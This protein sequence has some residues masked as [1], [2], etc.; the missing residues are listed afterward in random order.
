MKLAK[1]A[2][3]LAAIAALTALVGVSAASAAQY[4]SSASPVSLSGNQNN[5]IVFSIHGQN[6]SCTS[7]ILT[8]NGLATPANEVSGVVVSFS[9][10]TA[11][12]FAAAINMG[13][14]T[15]NFD[16]PNAGLT[17]TT[18]VVCTSN[19]NVTGNATNNGDARILTNVFGSVCEVHLESQNNK[20]TITF[21]NNNPVAGDFLVM[22]ALNSLTAEVTQDNGLCPLSGTGVTNTATLNGS[23]GVTGDG[24]TTVSIG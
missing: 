8:R 7:V 15:F 22:F 4:K 1:P 20:G 10:C 6:L 9:G 5:T 21:V 14:C 2:L 12:G 17:A 13:T 11:F 3:A 18:D 16:T 19:A 23:M 24:A